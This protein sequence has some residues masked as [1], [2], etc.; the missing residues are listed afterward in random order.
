MALDCVEALVWCMKSLGREH[1]D[2]IAL[3]NATWDM[4]KASDKM[5]TTTLL[6]NRAALERVAAREA[7]GE[8]FTPEAAIKLLAEWRQEMRTKAGL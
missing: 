5:V 4:V 8:T 2:A 7:L 1:A 3:L 6:V